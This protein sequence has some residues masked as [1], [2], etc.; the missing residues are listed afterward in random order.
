MLRCC[1]CETAFESEDSL[2]DICNEE[3]LIDGEWET[4]DRWSLWSFDDLPKDDQTHR[5]YT[6]KGCPYCL[7]DDFLIKI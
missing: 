7:T 2:G 4:T 6:F 1:N 3:T 5:Y